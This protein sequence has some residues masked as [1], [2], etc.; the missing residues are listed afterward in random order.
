MPGFSTFLRL[1]IMKIAARHFTKKCL[2]LVFVFRK[3]SIPSSVQIFSVLFVEGF[4]E[5]MTIP[6]IG[7]VLEENVFFFSKHILV[8]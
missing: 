8:W 5:M 6:N 7:S 2:F 1:R 4:K 3:K